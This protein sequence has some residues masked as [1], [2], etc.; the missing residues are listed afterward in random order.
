MMSGI[1]R[2]VAALCFVVAWSVGGASAQENTAKDRSQ[3]AN[4]DPVRKKWFE[5]QQMNEAARRR[6]DVP[7]KS[8]CDNGDVF[9]TRFRVGVS[10]EDQWEYLD[11]AT[12][13]V[14]PADIIKDDP[15]LDSEPILFRNR[16]DG[17]ELCFFKPNG[18]L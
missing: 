6:L 17:R 9:R 2:K 15:S 5:S 10:N 3:W 14:I 1:A 18:G 4:S 13:K 7:Y 16:R 12:W 8:C 11:G